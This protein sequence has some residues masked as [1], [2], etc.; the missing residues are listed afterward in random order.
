MA[1]EY[2]TV[3]TQAGLAYEAKSKAEKTPINLSYLA[4]GDGNGAPYNPGPEATQLLRETHRQPLNALSQDDKNP[5]WLMAEAL[6]PEDVGG[7]TI[8]EVGIYT[9]TGILYA[10]GKYPDSIKPLLPGGSTK[11]FYVKAIFQTSNA[12]DVILIVDN[13]VVAATRSF[14]IDYVRSELDRRYLGGLQLLE[15]SQAPRVFELPAADEVLEIIVRRTDNS[16]HRLLINASGGGTIKF[17]THLNPDGYPFF[18]LMGAGD[19]WHL[20]SDGQGSWWPMGRHDSTPLGRPVFETTTV[21]NPGGYGPLNGPVL[22][23]TDWPWLWDHAQ[24]SGMNVPEALRDGNEGGWTEGD[25]DQTFRAPEGRGE[26]LRV[27]D[28]NRGVDP[29]RVPGSN[30]APEIQA[31]AHTMEFNMDRSSGAMGNAVYGDEQYYGTNSAGTKPTGGT[32]TRPR[33]I[34]YPGRIKLI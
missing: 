3:L 24:Q 4:V 27:L 31:H 17:H 16:G 11:Q 21:F 2:Y 19:W 8:R 30:Q 5:S 33:N 28:E 18:V 26:F 7:W 6:L 22:V 25:G 1:Q 32:E 34:A 9:D 12:A 20:R 10:I 23:R 29:V 15:A 13:N 14:V